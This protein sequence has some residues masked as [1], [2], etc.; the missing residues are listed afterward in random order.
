MLYHWLR[1]WAS[2]AAS[3][4]LIACT[5]CHD[6]MLCYDPGVNADQVTGQ[7][8]KSACAAL[9]A[10]CW[11]LHVDDHRATM[12]CRHRASVSV[13]DADRLE[14]QQSSAQPNRC[15]HGQ[16]VC[17]WAV[18][19]LCGGG[20]G[21]LCNAMCH[22]RFRVVLLLTPRS[23]TEQQMDGSNHPERELPTHTQT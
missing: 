2:R 20:G 19:S 16:H 22:M 9:P 4:V 7:L 18:D 17:T 3:A 11:N 1:A 6:T 8:T 5:V 10:S 23:G 12:V 14:W 13:Y 15:L 21:R